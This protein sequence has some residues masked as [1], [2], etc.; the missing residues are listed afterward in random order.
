MRKLDD[1][2]SS[3][4]RVDT[5]D[6]WSDVL[7]REP[8]SAPSGPS[9]PR[10]LAIAAAALAVFVA[11]F[12]FVTTSFGQRS[13]PRATPTGF[14]ST[15]VPGSHMAPTWLSDEAATMA[16]ANG[17]A[18]PSSAQWVLTDA[19][20]AAPAVGLENGD[21]GL[22]VYLVVMRGDFIAYQAKAPAGASLP[23]GTVMTFTAD[24]SSRTITDWGVSD[25]VPQI[26][27]LQ[28]LA[29]ERSPTPGPS[30]PAGNRFVRPV[31][32]LP[33]TSTAIAPSSDGSIYISVSTAAGPRIVERWDPA[34][35]DVVRSGL[36]PGMQLVVSNGAV[37]ASG[38][39]PPSWDAP[40]APALYRL[41]PAS[42]AVVQTVDLPSAP[43]AF[44]VA[45]DGSLWVGVK[46]GI[47]I[48]DGS[49]GAIQRSFEVR[50]T[51]KLFA[52]DPSG[53][54]A[55]VSTDAP[56]GQD[57][58]LLIELDATTGGVVA[59][60]SAGIHELDGPTSMAATDRG[61][62]VTEPTGM[63]AS[64]SFLAEGTLRRS[65]D[66]SHEGSNGLTVTIAGG[67][68]WLTD[69]RVSCLDP[70]TGRRRAQFDLSTGGSDLQGRSVIDS[71]AGLLMDGADYV[72]RLDPPP[73]CSANP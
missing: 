5:P 8:R 60:G 22:E 30:L 40:S 68:V 50:G 66:H 58:D 62:W 39:V 64:A 47:I 29:L 53:A 31:L 59:S 35:G 73:A 49:T 3:L 36:I 41:D 27:G 19:D 16:A 20:T 17:D 57:S 1:G 21:P 65:G 25:V 52:F 26:P 9:R 38:G 15:S 24:A 72:L 18:S 33:G 7:E 34:T 45:P 43:A 4:A 23:R 14:R 2:F 69:L 56:S 51:P 71:P 63:M 28:P 61:V 12:A 37:W 11:A 70:A 13:S 67:V 32:A 46:G 44:S 48:V 55:Y 54:H 6:V 10:R 42:L